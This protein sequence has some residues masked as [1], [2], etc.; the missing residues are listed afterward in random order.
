[1][2]SLVEPGAHLA[3]LVPAH[4]WLYGRYD[5]LDGHF[6]RYSKHSLCELLSRT[7]FEVL[8]LHYFN[9]IGALGWWVQYRLLRRQVHGQESF[10]A[11]NAILP[12]LRVAER[13]IEPPFGL[14]VV[15]L[16]RR[17]ED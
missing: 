3:L 17:C 6:R 11:M 7:P 16:C 2:A 12:A 14:S 9:S 15:A 1:M 8:D 10:G 5:E 13:L 4:Q